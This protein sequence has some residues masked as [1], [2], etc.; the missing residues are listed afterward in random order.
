M[1]YES[2][3][4]A[5]LN[6]TAPHFF[7]TV[8]R[9][10][11]VSIFTCI[12]ALTDPPASKFDENLSLRGLSARLTASGHPLAGLFFEMTKDYVAKAKPVY[13][14]VSKKIAHFDADHAIGAKKDASFEIDSDEIEALIDD[15]ARLLDFASGTITIRPKGAQ[16]G[17]AAEVLRRLGV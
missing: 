6:A 13:L 7:R 17:G 3:D 14:A 10:L 12:R 1:F 5:V 16:P 9:A 4:V 2:S 8:Q 15:A 11:V